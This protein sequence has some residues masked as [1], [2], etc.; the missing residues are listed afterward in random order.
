MCASDARGGR[1]QVWICGETKSSASKNQPYSPHW[2]R[3]AR[4]DSAMNRCLWIGSLACLLVMSTGCLHHN[5]RGGCGGGCASGACGGGGCSTGNCGS[6]CNDGS[7]NS[8]SSCN[9]SGV[10]GKIGT[11][12]GIGN[13]CG[14]GGCGG[15]VGCET[16]P[17]GWQQGG[18]RYSSHLNPGALGCQASQ[19]LQN[20]PFTP[21]PPTAQV[22]YP[23]YTVR[24]PRDFLVDN[25]PTIGR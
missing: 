5:T 9:S 17:L 15:R 10:I 13:G 12:C 24:G 25:P 6:G 23:Y 16:G 20:R 8:C 14:C 3:D 4:K 2:W 7:C 22:G 19:A 21:G 18:L 11:L 1:K